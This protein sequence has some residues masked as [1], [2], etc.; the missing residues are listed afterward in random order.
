MLTE[1]IVRDAKPGPK[2]TILWDGQIKGLGCRVFPSGHRAYVLSYRTGQRKHLATIGRCL[3]LSLRQARERA[4]A[5]LA[6]IRQGEGDPLERRR[7]EREA[8]TVNDALKKFFDETVPQRIAAG[9]FS[10]R[11]AREYTWQAQRYVAPALGTMQV[12]KVTRHDV[13][14]LAATLADRPSQR[15]RVLAF[16]S[17]IFTLTE[18]WEWRPQHTNPIRGIERGREEPRP[19]ILSREELASLSRA[20]KDAEPKWPPSVAAIRVAALSGLRISEVIAMRWAD[21]D[22]ESGRVNLPRTKTGPRVHD[23]PAA[24]LALVNALPR[25]NEWI[26]TNGRSAPVAYRTVRRHFLEI[27][28]GASLEEVRLHDLRRTLITVA[29]ASGE[30]VFVIR[31]LLGHETT[32]IAARYVQEAGLAVREARERAGRTVAAM[33]DGPAG[34][35][36]PASPGD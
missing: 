13:E 21:V 14:K 12:S 18:R 31:G 3:E 28:A 4:R 30:S 29:A 36:W 25:V 7:R 2:P 11:T 17:R 6:Q 10:E 5:E 22:F 20:L 9:R 23:L 19:R 33:M 34:E 27:V 8:P 26:F 32:Q 35:E 24:S 16:M 15:N 1:R